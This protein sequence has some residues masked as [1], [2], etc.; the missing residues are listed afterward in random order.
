MFLF[1]ITLIHIKFYPKAPKIFLM[2]TVQQAI[3]ISFPS[4]WRD[5]GRDWHHRSFP[6]S[7]NTNLHFTIYSITDSWGF[8]QITQISGAERP[9]FNQ[10]FE[11]YQQ[12]FIKR[13]IIKRLMI[14][15]HF[16]LQRERGRE[17]ESRFSYWKYISWMS[18]SI[19]Q[20]EGFP[21]LLLLFLKVHF[22]H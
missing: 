18:E 1:Q 4:W 22:M 13:L 5:V 14:V 16:L 8:K 15:Q 12:I 9:N 7:K 3:E 2:L 10:V 6:S 19:K 11:K 21:L 20:S 17:R